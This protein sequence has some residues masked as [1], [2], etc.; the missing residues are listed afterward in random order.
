MT[1]AGFHFTNGDGVAFTF[2]AGILQQGGSYFDSDGKHFTFDT[3]EAR[4][5][6]QLMVDMAQKYKIVDPILFNDEAGPIQTTFFTGNVGIGF[7][8]SYAAAEGQASYPDINL[9]YTAIP[10]YFGDKQLYAAD[11]GWGKVVSKNTKHPDEAWKLAQYMTTNPD[12]A[13]QFAI[14]STT[15]PA[16]KSLVE[17]PEELLAGAP[18]LESILPILPNGTFIGDVTDRDQLFYEILYPNL[19]EAMQG[20]ITVDEAVKKINTEANAMVDANK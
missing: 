16:I 10:P 12:E 5:I 9:D 2:L 7:I 1:K 15:I 19:L 3:P 11:S 17:N 20:N 14:K 8:G 4:N 18:F 6:A 13:L